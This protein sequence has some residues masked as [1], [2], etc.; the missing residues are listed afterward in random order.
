MQKSRR[1]CCTCLVTLATLTGCFSLSLS[2]FLDCVLALTQDEEPESLPPELL[3]VEVEVPGL[4]EGV[5]VPVGPTAQHALLTED[6][7]G[8]G[9]V[10]KHLTKSPVGLASLPHLTWCICSLSIPGAK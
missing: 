10:Q 4:V 1:V 5:H 8:G 7:L 2:L 3:E 9:G 6:H